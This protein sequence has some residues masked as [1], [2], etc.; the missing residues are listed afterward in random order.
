MWRGVLR[1]WRMLQD[2][3]VS[4]GRMRVGCTKLGDLS[5]KSVDVVCRRVRG[6]GAQRT[7]HTGSLPPLCLAKEVQ[8]YSC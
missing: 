6:S 1:C 4:L 7:L 3:G 5:G 8:L 2:D